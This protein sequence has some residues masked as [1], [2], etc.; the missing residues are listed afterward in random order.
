MLFYYIICMGQEEMHLTKC[1]WSVWRYIFNMKLFYSALPALQTKHQLILRKSQTQKQREW[2]AKHLSPCNPLVYPLLL[3]WFDP[4]LS[5]YA[6]LKRFSSMVHHLII[7]SY[8]LAN[9]YCKNIYIILTTAELTE[10]YSDIKYFWFCLGHPKRPPKEP[11]RNLDPILQ[12]LIW[13]HLWPQDKTLLWK[14][15]EH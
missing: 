7:V 13:D 8:R 1:R 3:I 15:L 12:W 10:I 14:D 11:C 4:F 2:A 5:F 9:Y 6:P